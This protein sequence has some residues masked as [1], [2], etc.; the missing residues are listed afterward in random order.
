MISHDGN[1]IITGNSNGQIISFPIENN[2][3]PCITSSH[4]NDG[5]TSIDCSLNLISSVGLDHYC[6]I[7]DS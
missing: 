4:S 5:I 7:Y 6:V 3:D 2:N 1:F